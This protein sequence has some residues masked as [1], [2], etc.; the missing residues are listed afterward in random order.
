[1]VGR[2]QSNALFLREPLSPPPPATPTG[3]EFEERTESPRVP[4]SRFC[5]F[6]CFRRRGR[7]P[8]LFR[9][10]PLSRARF[11]GSVSNRVFVAQNPEGPGRDLWSVV[12][13]AAVSLRSL[14]ATITVGRRVTIS[15]QTSA[16][17]RHATRGP[18]ASTLPAPQPFY[19]S[20]ALSAS[21]EAF[22]SPR[23]MSVFSL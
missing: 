19:A 14:A 1:M 11:M 20:A 2:R 7:D 12:A 15:S 16:A 9:V 5:G 22:A 13:A 8:R 6:K 21:Q 17:L 23:S 3:Q 10:P 4:D 18:H